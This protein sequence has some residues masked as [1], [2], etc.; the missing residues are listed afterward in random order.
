MSIPTSIL[1]LADGLVLSGRQIGDPGTIGGELVFNTSMTGYQEILTDP[2]YAGE[3][4][5]FTFPLI[6][7]YGWTADDHQSRRI[8]ANGVVVSTLHGGIDNWMAEKTLADR[9]AEGGVRGIEG[10]D[11]RAV[12]KRLR[13]AGAMNCII[14]TELSEGEAVKAAQDWPDLDEQDLVGGVTCESAYDWDAPVEPKFRV[15]AFDCGIKFGILRAMAERGVAT[16]V[17]PA[18]ATADEVK[19]WRPDGVFLSN[20][21]GDPQAC[22]HYLRDT[23]SGLAGEYPIMGICLGHQLVGLAYGLETYKLKFGHRGANHPVKDL[24][25]GRVYITSQNH[26]YA[27]REP[28]GD[29]PLELTHL[30]VNDGSVEG[31]RH[32]SLS[33][34]TVQYHPEGSPGPRDNLYLFDEFAGMMEAAKSGAPV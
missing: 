18:T 22:I 16:R 3:I 14:T 29:C 9:L 25:T 8:W 31:F 13:T 33:V 23:I 32:K 11:T 12:T 20:G 7:N 2:S 28:D 4:I 30:N 19:A 15:A 6:G 10:V 17:F 5:T 26:G 34:F 24:K 27:V 1:A 21:P